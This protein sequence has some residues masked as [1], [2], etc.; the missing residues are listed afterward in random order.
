MPVHILNRMRGEIIPFQRLTELRADLNGKRGARF[1]KS[2]AA[3]AREF[4]S[5][6]VQ[7]PAGSETIEDDDS[8]LFCIGYG[9]CHLGRKRVKGSF[10]LSIRCGQYRR[11]N[12]RWRWLRPYRWGSTRLD[13]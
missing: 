6:G 5:R 4:L 8:F 13:A 1:R 7:L 12:L 9:A 2:T 3:I 11:K 10:H